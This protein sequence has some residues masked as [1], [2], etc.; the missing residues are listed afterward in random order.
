[1]S[2]ETELEDLAR[3]LAEYTARRERPG[4]PLDDAT[5]NAYRASADDEQRVVELDTRL[6][7]DPIARKRLVELAGLEDAPESVRGRLL[8]SDSRNN[9]PASARS[10]WRTVALAAALAAIAVALGT[11]LWP[12]SDES[13]WPPVIAQGLGERAFGVTVTGL[14]QVRSGPVR[15]V[16]VPQAYPDTTLRARMAA[17]VTLPVPLFFGVFVLRDG[18]LVPVDRARVDAAGSAA[19]IS[20]SPRD[21]G[22]SGAG[23][24][25]LVFVASGVPLPGTP[26]AFADVDERWYR[27]R[28]KV[29]VIA[30]PPD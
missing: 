29:E 27:H 14:A 26:F 23:P 28:Q 13:Q 7:S 12:Q 8:G 24:L 2:D 10:G 6:A 18:V 19:D 25:D 5:L 1:M 16:N 11:W 15:E 30:A 17:D 9:L 3:K 21:A 20:L 22:V 4:A